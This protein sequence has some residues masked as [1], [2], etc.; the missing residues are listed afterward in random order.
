MKSLCLARLGRGEARLPPFQSISVL[1]GLC[2]QKMC[3]PAGQDHCSWTDSGI[4]NMLLLKE[5]AAHKQHLYIHC[6][7]KLC[8]CLINLR[9]TIKFSES[10]LITS[11][12]V[13]EMTTTSIARCYLVINANKNDFSK[14]FLH[15]SS[16]GLF[17]LQALSQQQLYPS[18]LSLSLLQELGNSQQLEIISISLLSENTCDG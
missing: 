13:S 10:L 17:I 15:S 16:T 11:K 14:L 5:S 9:E 7:C 1:M 18:N 8:Y 4:L 6:N 2:S 12:G 3:H